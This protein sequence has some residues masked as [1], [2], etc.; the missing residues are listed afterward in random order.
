MPPVERNSKQSSESTTIN[1]QPIILIA[2]L[3][4]PQPSTFL[5][6][7]AEQRTLASH[8]LFSNDYFNFQLQ[9]KH[10]VH[11]TSR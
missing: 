10:R 3:Q 4:P 5:E 9:S 2:E 6:G 7:W 1:K 11:R 8:T